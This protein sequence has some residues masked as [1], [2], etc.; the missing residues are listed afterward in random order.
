MKEEIS[1][2]CNRIVD[3]LNEKRLEIKEKYKN[4]DSFCISLCTDYENIAIG[5]CACLFKLHLISGPEHKELCSRIR[6]VK[7][8]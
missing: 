2:F 8:Y 4:D 1:I 5:E 6:E 3:E 7:I